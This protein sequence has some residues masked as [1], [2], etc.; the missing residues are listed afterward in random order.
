M[1]T[2]PYL[3]YSALARY[4]AMF[5]PLVSSLYMAPAHPKAIKEQTGTNKQE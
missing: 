5:L 4:I 3:L 2:T 1:F